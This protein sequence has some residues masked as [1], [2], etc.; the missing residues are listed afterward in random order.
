MSKKS[1][2]RQFSDKQA[3]ASA[4]AIR[5][6][7]QKMGLIAGLIR[8]KPVNEAL[9][10]LTFSKRRVSGEVKKVLSAAVANAENNHQLDIDRLFVSRVE[11][12]RALVMK[13]FRARAKG[14]GAKILKVSSNLKIIVEQREESN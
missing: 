9:A 10:Q 8:N 13:R 5:T 7:P 6:S 2:P 1:L 14:R 3:I 11:V 12:G 4:K